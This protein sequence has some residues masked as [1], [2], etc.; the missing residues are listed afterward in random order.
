MLPEASRVVFWQG[1]A[2]DLERLGDLPWGSR[3]RRAGWIPCRL[4]RPGRTWLA[5]GLFDLGRSGRG[6]RR[7]SCSLQYDRGS[8]LVSE[9]RGVCFQ[10]GCCNVNRAGDRVL[11][12]QLTAYLSSAR[13]PG[14]SCGCPGSWSGCGRATSLWP[15]L[16]VLIGQRGDA[17]HA[18]HQVEDDASVERMLAALARMTAMAWLFLTRTPSKIS[19]WRDDLEAADWIGGEFAVDARKAEM[20]PMPAVTS[21]AWRRWWRWRACRGRW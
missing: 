20:Q 12:P 21:S 17:A 19:G 15:P 10:R 7:A 1:F 14:W 2:D 9:R 4:R 5:C 6:L 8:S 13:R 16:G 3:R 11:L 18:L